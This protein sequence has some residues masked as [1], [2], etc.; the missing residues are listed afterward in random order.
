VHNVIRCF[1]VS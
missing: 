1:V